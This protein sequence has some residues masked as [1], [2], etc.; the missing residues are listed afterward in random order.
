MSKA[1]GIVMF[2]HCLK[3]IHCFVLRFLAAF[4]LPTRSITFSQAIVPNKC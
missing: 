3:G 4:S 2:K 1:L